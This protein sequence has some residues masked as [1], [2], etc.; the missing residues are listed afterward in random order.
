MKPF[1]IFF[2]ILI[3]SPSVFSYDDSQRYKV[4]KFYKEKAQKAVDNSVK[5]LKG[6]CRIMLS[7]HHLDQKYAKL[8]RV[9]ANGNSLVCK[10]AK[11]ELKKYKNQKITYDTPEKL[12]RLTISTGH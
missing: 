11:K 4:A 9:R 1:T 12:L 5:H 7:M 2:C 8:K 3:I 10:A 6:E